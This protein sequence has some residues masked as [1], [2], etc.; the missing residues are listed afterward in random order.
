MQLKITYLIAAIDRNRPVTDLKYLNILLDE[1]QQVPSTTVKAFIGD[2][3]EIDTLKE[4]H[5]K[6]LNYHFE[7]VHK[8]LCG[9]RKIDQKTVE[10][11]YICTVNYFPGIQKAGDI[12]T[13]QDIQEE[14]IL[15]EEYYGEIFFKFGPSTFR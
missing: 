6:F 4:L 5:D 10:I 13:L 2:K 3:D 8:M 15:L 1:N 7:Y 12:Y 14:N 9:F 11:V